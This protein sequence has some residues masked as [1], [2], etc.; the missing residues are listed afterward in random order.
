MRNAGVLAHGAG[1]TRRG[2]S[3]PNGCV[4][5]IRVKRPEPSSASSC[6]KACDIVRGYYNSASDA[7]TLTCYT[8]PQ[9]GGV[10]SCCSDWPVQWNAPVKG[11]LQLS[12]GQAGFFMTINGLPLKLRSAACP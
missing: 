12:P 4:R 6:C 3:G 2:V 5:S 10:Q 8:P 9:C 11:S 1:K 7:A